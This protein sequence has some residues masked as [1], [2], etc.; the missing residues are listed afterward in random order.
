M[1]L[2]IIIFYISLIMLFYTY[3]G[4]PFLL[5]FL[6]KFII[7]EVN[8]G[9]Y[10]PDITMII[11][12]HNEENVI[13]KKLENCLALDYP[14]DKFKIIVASDASTDGTE[15]IVSDFASDP[16]KWVALEK[17]GGKV[18]AQNAAI[19]HVNSEVIVFTDA[20]IRMNKD[21]LKQIVQ[22]F[23]DKNV[24]AVSCRDHII[25]NSKNANEESSYIKYDMV[26]R[27]YLSQI[28]TLI[29]VTG[30]FYAIR[31]ELTD[32]GWET[33][34]P[35]DFNAALKCIRKG[36]RVIED[37]TVE[38][39]YKTTE[40]SSDEFKRKV[41]TLNRGMH[42]L[43]ANLDLLNPFTY[44]FT[45]LTLLSHKLFRWLTPL[46]FMALFLSNALLWKQGIFYTTMFIIQS[47]IILLIIVSILSL[48][49]LRNVKLIKLLKFFFISNLALIKAWYELLIGKKYFIW[50]PTQR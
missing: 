9:S 34:F 17:R 4:Y 30:G 13:Q 10:L 49:L 43:F 3:I 33:E 18:A 20:A 15:K 36:Y 6:S 22:N 1:S 40:K 47:I 26:V 7:R 35:P 19:E 41:R 28:N 16:V 42:A 27:K 48:P 44:G 31:R 21:A 37:P 45:A 25:D 32:G 2:A 39:F 8:R 38:A 29:G 23:N 46:F 11:P 50:Q 24:G 5:F 14:K 12:V